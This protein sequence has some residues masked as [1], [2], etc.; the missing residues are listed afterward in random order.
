LTVNYIQLY[1]PHT[2]MSHLKII[3]S[4]FAAFSWS[5]IADWWY[6]SNNS[7]RKILF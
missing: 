7:A 3:C 5:K 1:S 4:D 6:T 2:G